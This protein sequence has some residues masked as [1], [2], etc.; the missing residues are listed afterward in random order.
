MATQLP[1]PG[2]AI[3]PPTITFA[4]SPET[5]VTVG[6]ARMRATLLRSN[7]WTDSDVL[8]GPFRVSEALLSCPLIEKGL[9]LVSVPQ[10]PLNRVSA[11]LVG[12]AETPS[13][14]ST[15]RETSATVTFSIT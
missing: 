9:L 15:V 2:T 1:G 11:P 6:S 3:S 10:P 7:A 4:I 12:L 8:P 5:A 13:C 14:L